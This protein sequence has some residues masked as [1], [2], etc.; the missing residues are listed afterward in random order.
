[1]SINLNWRWNNR[2]IPIQ[3]LNDYQLEQTLSFLKR[4]KKTHFQN[5]RKDQWIR[6]IRQV[7]V[8]KEEQ[9]FNNF[10]NNINL[11]KQ[12]KITSTVDK[13]IETVFPNDFKVL[14]RI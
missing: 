5:I 3:E 9:E 4:T 14:K 6:K 8:Q 11:R 13:F 12:E 2:F 1:M 10:L 7:I